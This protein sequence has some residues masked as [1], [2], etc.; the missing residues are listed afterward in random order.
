MDNLRLNTA[1]QETCFYRGDH[2][3]EMLE[4]AIPPGHGTRA[5][6]EVFLKYQ[7]L[8]AHS[9]IE[10]VLESTCLTLKS[11]GTRPAPEG[12]EGEMQR[13]LESEVAAI[14]E[15]TRETTAHSA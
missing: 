1:W 6:A 9:K 4:I 15:V 2:H 10:A 12:A 13:E 11:L 7:D 14:E 3:V 8:V 5:V